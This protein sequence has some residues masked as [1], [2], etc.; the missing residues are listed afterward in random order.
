MGTNCST[1]IAL[2]ICGGNVFVLVD[3]FD[4]Q[5][6]KILNGSFWHFVSLTLVIVFFLWNSTKPRVTVVVLNKTSLQI[7]NGIS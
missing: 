5:L 7:L 1:V 2:W 3:H 6:L 4:S